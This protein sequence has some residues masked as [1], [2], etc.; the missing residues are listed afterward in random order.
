MI[1]VR[2]FNK[3]RYS[4]VEILSILQALIESLELL[5]H[6]RIEHRVWLSDGERGTEHPELELVTCKRERTCSV[7]VCRIL[8]NRGKN[9]NTEL[10]LLLCPSWS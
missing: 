2:L 4:L 5:R 8:R 6:N 1:D 10:H 9:M 3:I 7:P